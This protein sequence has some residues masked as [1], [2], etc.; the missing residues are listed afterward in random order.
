MK[1]KKRFAKSLL[2]L[3]L[4]ISFFIP[5]LSAPILVPND[6]IVSFYSDIPGVFTQN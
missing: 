3:F 1:S 5:T 4:C 6:N 2:I